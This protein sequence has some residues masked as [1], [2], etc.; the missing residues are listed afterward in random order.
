METLTCKNCGGSTFEKKGNDYICQH[1]G[2][3]MVPQVRM[4]R[5]RLILII[6]LLVLLVLGLF[7]LYQTLYSV[8]KDI[9]GL[10]TGE[11]I[12]NKQGKN[13]EDNPFR[14]L[15]ESIQKKVKN[16]LNYSP[17]EKMMTAYHKMPEHKAFFIAIT[18]KGIYSYGYSYNYGTI[19]EATKSA[20]NYCEERRKK[21]KMSE[22]CSPYLVDN[23]VAKSIAE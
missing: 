18:R 4:P 7:A 1:C 2:S 22:I 11:T 20:F 5:K 19:K 3:I 21:M 9:E 12:Q 14:K 17:L 23:R 6:A 16:K 10:S 15:K 8:K 13:T